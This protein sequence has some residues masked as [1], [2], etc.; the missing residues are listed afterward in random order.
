MM[1]VRL[2][3][4]LLNIGECSYHKSS[5]ALLYNDLRLK[6]ILICVEVYANRFIGLTFSPV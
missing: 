4:G 5:L 3:G 6:E 2:F 1:I